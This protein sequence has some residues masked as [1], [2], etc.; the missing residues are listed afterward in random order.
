MADPY[1][2]TQPIR[3]YKSND[4]YY[5]EVD[6]IPLRQLEENILFI[7]DKI[8]GGESGSQFLTT[9]SEINIHQIKQLKPKIAAAG[10]RTVQVNAGRFVG[11]V[12]D[13]FS[14]TKPLAH[15]IFGDGQKAILPNVIPSL[16]TAWT[17]ARRD[18]VW[19]D[20]ITGSAAANKAYNMNGIGTH[21]GFH[22]VPM[23][24]M[25]SAWTVTDANPHFPTRNY[26]NYAG[27]G[28]TWM[29]AG[30]PGQ[31][32]HG[33]I[34]AQGAGIFWA[35]PVDFPSK[36]LKGAD[37]VP[38]VNLAFIQQWRGIFRTS[39][40]DMDD[41]T[42]AI[43]SWSDEDFMYQDEANGD[44]V[45]LDASQRI[46]LLVVY[47]M[48]IDSSSTTLSDYSLNYNIPSN[49]QTPK[50]ITVPTLGIVRGAGVGI[51]LDTGGQYR[52]AATTGLGGEGPPPTGEA[53]ILANT[54]DFETGAN[55]GIRDING[56]RVHGSFPSPDD[57][58]NQAP[59]LALDVESDNLELIGQAA[60][61]IAYIITKKGQNE[62]VEAD[63]IDIRP[64]LR[65]T[66]LLTMSE[67][68]LVLPILL[69][70]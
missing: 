6:N 68:V 40:V 61:P 59:V 46:D 50:T 66:E 52:I 24:G 9:T 30:W 63:I 14:I 62:L 70:L 58:L 11:R 39:V 15:L 64:F 45:K 1:S 28:A 29:G 48:S 3:Y 38:T 51:S 65:T 32:L 4:P 35:G 25:G 7:K 26:P 33:S 44:W 20:F 36:P 22:S 31:N 54:S 16:D 18:A 37:L 42:I 60:L 41:Q 13:A 12:N 43:P 23:D 55:I 57:L 21:Y 10:G 27:T 17:E 19:N 34:A 47:G 56:S 5:Y 69:F 8:E 2:F 67:Q 49:P 53:M